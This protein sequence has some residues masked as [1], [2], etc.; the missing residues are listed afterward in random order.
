MSTVRCFQNDAGHESTSVKLKERD[1]EY[2]DR[3]RNRDRRHF[4]V[5]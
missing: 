5:T 1:G 2:Y 3:C 4:V